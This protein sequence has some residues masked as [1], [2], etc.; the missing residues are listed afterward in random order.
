MKRLTKRYL[1]A[2]LR[3]LDNTDPKAKLT[4]RS[5]RNGRGAWTQEFYIDGVL[6]HTI[7]GGSIPPVVTY[8][9]ALHAIGG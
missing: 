6:S 9:P 4:C 5:Y 3:S 7:E 1:K 8:N 2:F